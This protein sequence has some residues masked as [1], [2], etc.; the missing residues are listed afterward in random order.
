MRRE[1]SD[2]V[3]ARFPITPFTYPGGEID[4]KIPRDTPH[5]GE[6]IAYLQGAD[7]ADLITLPL[8]ADA[9]YRYAARPVLLLPYLPAARSDRGAPTG[10]SAYTDLI[11]AL[12]LDTLVYLDPHSDVMPGL[13][14]HAAPRTIQVDLLSVVLDSIGRVDRYAGVIAPDHGATGRAS[15]I[16]D[17]LGI[18]LYRAA[19]HRDFETGKL[20]TFSCEELPEQG[21][22][23]V[24]DD[25]CDGGG[26]FMGLA[27][28]TGLGPDR[29]DLWVTHG[30]FSGKA[31]LLREHYE[32]IYTTDSHHNQTDQGVATH[33]TPALPYLL[34]ALDEP[35]TLTVTA[36][37][38]VEIRVPLDTTIDLDEFEAWAG[39]GTEP[40]PDVVLEFIES[41]RDVD[42]FIGDFPNADPVEH[43]VLDAYLDTV[44]IHPNTAE[45]N[46][47]A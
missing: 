7:P 37:A 26:T 35:R 46:K 17:A 16:A 38:V 3:F 29:L 27:A 42:E 2:G 19:K 10:A 43:E 15:L 21:R 4:L 11:K 41:S 28:A 20:T 24:V 40:T 45:E 32:R 13:L 9:A 30:I 12:R 1:S 8:W 47:P 18:P 33:V 34:R 22:F 36:Y 44:K 25:I 14:Q 6:W 39:V 5:G 23:L 31:H